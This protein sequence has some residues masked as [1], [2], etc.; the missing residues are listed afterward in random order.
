M[1]QENLQA[2][3]DNE[4]ILSVE[5]NEPG[6]SVVRHIREMTFTPNNLRIFWEKA[7]PFKTIFNEEIKDDFQKFVRVIIDTEHKD[8]PRPN[9][10]FWVVD[11]FVGAFY[12]TNIESGGDGLAH[13]SFFDGRHKGRIDLVKSMM[14]YFFETYKFRRISVHIPRYN[15]DKTRNFVEKSLGFKCEGRKRKAAFFDGEWFD[16]NLY[17]ILREEVL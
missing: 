4:V 7:R 6:G 10:L 13:Y 15:T 14:K 12:V 17:G 8:G 1:Q 5:C 11:D 3:L 9:G 2:D 16:I